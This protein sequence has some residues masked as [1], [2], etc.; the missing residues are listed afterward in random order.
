VIV[1]ADRQYQVGLTC[2]NY[3]DQCS[4]FNTNTLRCEQC[5]SR[6]YTVSNGVCVQIKCEDRQYFDEASGSCLSVSFECGDFN[7]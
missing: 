2:V 7:K 5:S 3:P 6:R 4:V 1:C